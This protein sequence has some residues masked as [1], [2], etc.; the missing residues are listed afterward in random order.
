MSRYMAVPL[1]KNVLGEARRGVDGLRRYSGSVD[2][3]E[4]PWWPGGR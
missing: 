3:A 4:P 2:I 1:G